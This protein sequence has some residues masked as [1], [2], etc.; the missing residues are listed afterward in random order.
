M[1]IF[2]SG[3][4][5]KKQPLYFQTGVMELSG[6]TSKR[7]LSGERCAVVFGCSQGFSHME[8]T[9]LGKTFCR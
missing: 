5:K 9:Q 2:S 6:A 4:V 7:W 3:R 1:T 8:Y